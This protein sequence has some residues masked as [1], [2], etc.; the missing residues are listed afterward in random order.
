MRETSRNKL[1]SILLS[2]IVLTFHCLNFAS[3]WPSASNFKSF[4]I[5]KAIYSNSERSVQFLKQ[6]VF[7]FLLEVA[8]I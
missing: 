6:N 8:Q 2:K 5:T 7:N 4:E 3:S 1:K